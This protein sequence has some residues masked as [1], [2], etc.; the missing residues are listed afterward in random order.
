MKK[1]I[2]LFLTLLFL[3]AFTVVANA[4]ELS[5]EKIILINRFKDDLQKQQGIYGETYVGSTSVKVNN[6]SGNL[7]LIYK[8]LAKLK[9]SNLDLNYILN[10]PSKQMHVNADLLYGGKKYNQDVFVD[11]SKVIFTKTF[12]QFIGDVLPEG[13]LNELDSLPLYLY[14]NDPEIDDFWDEILR[15]KDIQIS[16]GL[17]ELIIEAI[18][19]KYI[20]RDD[21]YIKLT[22]DQKDLPEIMFSVIRKIKNEPDRFADNMAKLLV[23]FNQ[24]ISYEEIKTEILNNIGQLPDNVDDMEEAF[25]ELPFELTK[26]TFAIPVCSNGLTTVD[27]SGT[28]KDNDKKIGQIN[29]SLGQTNQCNNVAG[30]IKIDSNIQYDGYQI[31]AYISGNYSQS[32]TNARSDFVIDLDVK[33]NNIKLINIGLN[34]TSKEQV[35]KNAKIDIPELTPDNSFDFTESYDGEIE[36]DNG[37]NINEFE[38]FS[39]EGIIEK[40]INVFNP[41]QENGQ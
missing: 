30:N 2:I 40:R 1:A 15:S 33:N 7:L 29:L 39:E 19:D 35:D 24:D 3:L 4:Q 27:L 6:V 12:M 5:D 25:N 11:G 23:G 21:A 18:P 20:T 16:P 9:D 37:Q 31:K 22:F 41:M 28:I 38:D 10:A 8:E 17:F 34:V 36:S 14:G 32:L 13:D 26:F